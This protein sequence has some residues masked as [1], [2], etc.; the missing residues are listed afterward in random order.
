[1]LCYGVE[2]TLGLQ[3]GVGSHAICKSWREETKSRSSRGSTEGL[4][5]VFARATVKEGTSNA[6]HM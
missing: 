2:T 5:V 1:M 6:T 4:A 3:Y